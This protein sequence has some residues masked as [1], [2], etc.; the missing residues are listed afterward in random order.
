MK[1]FNKEETISKK[2]HVELI[3][4]LLKVH[5]EQL[6]IIYDGIDKVIQSRAMDNRGIKM[7]PTNPTRLELK[8]LR[9]KSIIHMR[10]VIA[11]LEKSKYE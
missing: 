3:R 10:Q 11:G 4:K 6:E 1:L 2:K 5:I 7:T 8:K 9:S